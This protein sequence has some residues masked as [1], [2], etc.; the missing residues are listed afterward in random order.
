MKSVYKFLPLAAVVSSAA[1]AVELAPA[2][3][4]EMVVSSARIPQNIDSTLGA[5]HV[6][7][8]ADIEQ[9]QVA[10]LDKFHRKSRK[11]AIE[12]YLTER[13]RGRLGDC[14]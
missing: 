12:R 9:A 1:S 13:D 3:Y 7:S 5:V 6:L 4:E 14:E 10:S 2:T 11:T 8:A